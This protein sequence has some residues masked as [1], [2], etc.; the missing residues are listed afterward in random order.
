M[1]S[2]LDVFVVIVT[3]VIRNSDSVPSI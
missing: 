3:L 1:I 2:R